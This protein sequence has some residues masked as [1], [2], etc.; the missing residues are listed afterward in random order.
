MRAPTYEAALKTLALA[1]ERVVVM[2]AENRAAIR[3]LPTVLGTRFIDTGITEQ[4][5]VGMAAGL[6]LRGR[7][8]VVHALAAFLTMRPFEFIRT[9]IGIP[10]LPVKLVG[11]VPGVL[12][13][14]NGPT[15]QALEDVA[16]MRGIPNMNV[17]CPADLEDLLL[18]LPVILAD[19]APWYVRYVDRPG[20]IR[21][22]P[23]FTIGRAEVLTWGRD[24]AI[25]TYG[26]LV[27]EAYA[28]A[29][30]LQDE[31]CS[32]RLVNLRTVKP[33]DEAA[34]MTAAR[35]CGLVVTIE[36][37][38]LTGGLHSI[39]AEVLLR[40]RMT[41][42]HLP[43]GFS[44]CWFTPALLPDVLRTEGLDPSR[45]ALRILAALGR[46]HR[47]GAAAS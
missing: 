7:I 11:G 19:P 26:A 14:A 22:D 6:A 13:E 10:A 46:P 18:G 23:E 43:I 32:V 30:E 36:D 37:H 5:M 15:H 35:T 12:S 17:F 47:R 20:V 27:R 34:I 33:V 44:E 4:T 8:P 41:A 21:H 29:Q 38:F 3:S 39:V 9:D 42:Y 25:L 45:I 2:T 40:H 28:A 16:L 24:V 1:N 31:G